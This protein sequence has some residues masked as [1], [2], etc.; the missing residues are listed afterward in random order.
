[1]GTECA[2]QPLLFD[3][4]DDFIY[5]D[6]E[7]VVQNQHLA[8]SHQTVVDK[9]VHRIAGQFVQF[10]NAALVK[11]RTSSTS[12]RLRPSSILTFSSTSRSSSMLETCA[13]AITC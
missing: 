11:F 1:M 5:A 9:H 2:S 3:R 4:G 12:I 13:S 7:I 10:D 8:A 6:T